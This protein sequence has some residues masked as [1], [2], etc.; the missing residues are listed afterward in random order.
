ME[1]N[2][3]EEVKQKQIKNA[4]DYRRYYIN[5]ISAQIEDLLK[6]LREINDIPENIINERVIRERIRWVKIND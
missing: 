3:K 1:M 2:T 4:I 5:Y 6:K